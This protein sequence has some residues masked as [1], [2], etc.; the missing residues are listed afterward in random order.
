MKLYELT[1]QWQA[2][3]DAISDADLTEDGEVDPEIVASLDAVGGEF[4]E[5]VDNICAL[6]RT[7]DATLAGVKSEQKRLAA[8][9]KALDSHM[10]WLKGYLLVNMTA[11]G[12]LKVEGP[13][14]RATVSSCPPSVNVIDEDLLPEAFL[15]AQ[16]PKV[17]KK[18]L[19]VALKAEQEVPGAVLVSDRKT[20]RIR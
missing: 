4:T 16:A 10:E 17:D 7:L 9:N 5:K 11:T 3:L 14:F 20:V 12:Q 19:L 6:V 2:L 15:V 13:R 1:D 18:A 8:Y